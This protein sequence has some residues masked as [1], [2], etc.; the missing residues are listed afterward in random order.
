M[1][2]HAISLF[3]I[4]LPASLVKSN[5]LSASHQEVEIGFP[6]PRRQTRLPPLQR[7]PWAAQSPQTAGLG[8]ACPRALPRPSAMPVTRLD[9]AI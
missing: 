7:G 4:T 5:S 6:S 2:Q 9:R 3:P 1:L 8:C